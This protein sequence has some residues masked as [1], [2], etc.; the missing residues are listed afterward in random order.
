M[1][2]SQSKESRY[3]DH[4]DCELVRLIGIEQDPSALTELYNRYRLPLGRFLRRHL[5]ESTLIDECYNDVM[6]LVWQHA[7]NFRS[8][9]KVSTWVFSIAYRVHIAASKK[10]KR[11]RHYNSEEVIDMVTSEQQAEVDAISETKTNLHD[12]L[13]ELPDSSR[14][15]IELSYF[16]GYSVVEISRIM[17]CP[18]NTA[19]TRLFYARKKL[20]ALIEAQSSSI[21]HKTI[22]DHKKCCEIKAKRHYRTPQVINQLSN[23]LRYSAAS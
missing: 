11:H 19:K 5:R 3:T 23:P 1:I 15:V 17:G 22:V 14:T 2:N 12:A 13:M 16:H 10:E 4:T 9:S 18:Q 8:E 21:Q 20:K 7:K 6:L